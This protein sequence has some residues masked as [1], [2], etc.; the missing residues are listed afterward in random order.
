[1]GCPVA[2]GQR[3]RGCLLSKTVLN[4]CLHQIVFDEC[5]KAKN[6]SSTKMG[7]AVLDLQSK[8]PLARVVYASATGGRGGA[9]CAVLRGCMCGEGGGGWSATRGY[10]GGGCSA[11]GGRAGGWNATGGAC[12]GA[13]HRGGACGGGGAPQGAVQGCVVLQQAHGAAGV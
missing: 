10:A 11:A 2:S 6:A 5:H 3:P 8:L 9:L 7:K 12:G 13:E 1:M 4:P